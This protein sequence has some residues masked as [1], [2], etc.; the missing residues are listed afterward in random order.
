MDNM[1]D[2]AD[3]I[4][5]NIWNFSIGLLLIPVVIAGFVYERIASA[6]VVGRNL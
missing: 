6:F 4:L 2:T 3:R 5:M 1:I